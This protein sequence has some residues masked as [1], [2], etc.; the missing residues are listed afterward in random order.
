MIDSAKQ[1]STIQLENTTIKIGCIYNKSTKIGIIHLGF[2]HS[3]WFILQKC[4]TW[5]HWIGTL[6]RCPISRWWWSLQL[7]CCILKIKMCTKVD[8]I[9]MV[10]LRYWPN[11]I[12]WNGSKSSSHEK[13][14]HQIHSWW[15]RLCNTTISRYSEIKV[16]VNQK[17]YIM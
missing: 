2:K 7:F 3:K 12:Q 17:L 6:F 9:R 15:W 14:N 4:C 13:S 8:M 10:N 1:S 11:K 16:F 5:L